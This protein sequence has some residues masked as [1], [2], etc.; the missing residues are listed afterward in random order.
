MTTPTLYSLLVLVFITL[1]LMIGV[2]QVLLHQ[3]TE[4]YECRMEVSPSRVSTASL[5]SAFRGVQ[6][7]SS[8]L[9][10][11]G[12][13]GHLRSVRSHSRPRRARC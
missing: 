2:Q 1:P 11:I 5:I 13:R 4:L 12:K 7:G 6:K 8:R 3:R 9:R 10:L